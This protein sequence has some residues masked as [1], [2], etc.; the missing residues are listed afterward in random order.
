MKGENIDMNNYILRVTSA[1]KSIRGFFAVTTGL[2]EKARTLH[3]TTPV[4]TAALGRAITAGSIMG[5]MIKGEND[6]LTL[7]IK[8][9]GPAG[10]IVVVSNYQGIVKGYIANPDVEVPLRE[11]GKLNVGAAIGREGKINVIIDMG[12][13]EP[14]VGQYSLV[15]GEIGEDLAHYFTFSEQTPSAVA[16]GVLIDRDHSVKAAGGFIVQPLP[17]AS[18]ESISRLEENISGMK[19]ITALIEEGKTPEDVMNIVLDGFEPEVLEK[20]EVD[21]QCDC[22]REKFEKALV[23]IGREEL[24]K[25][26]LEDGGAELVCHF[27][28]KKYN[29]SGE[30]LQKI[31]DTI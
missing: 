6:K 22:S 20:Y 30:E 21:Y 15:S 12:L 31:I 14:Y 17:D 2:A 19:P 13:K 11:D 3:N 1:D 10:G 5:L 8:G 4:A 16:L 27:C 24:E 25:I 28:N 7:Q 18:E 23:T 29:F 9:D 26:L